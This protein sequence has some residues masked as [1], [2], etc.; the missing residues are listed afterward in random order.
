MKD[1][2]GSVECHVFL[3]PIM[4]LKMHGAVPPLPIHLYIK[5]LIKHHLLYTFLL[6]AFVGTDLHQQIAHC[7]LM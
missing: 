6:S 7:H 4:K 2:M 3:N 5:V 1:F